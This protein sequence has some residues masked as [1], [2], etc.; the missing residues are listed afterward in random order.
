MLEK[1]TNKIV[2]DIYD[3]WKAEG[4]SQ[5][6]RTY[7]GGSQIGH[8]CERY[9]WYDFRHCTENVFSGRLYRLFQ[10]GHDEEHRF[11]KDLRDIGCEVWE[12]TEANEQFGVEACG[13]HFRGHLDGVARIPDYDK[14]H[15]LEFK[16]SNTKDF[17]KLEKED[18]QKES[19]EKQE[20]SSCGDN[21]DGEETKTEE[22]DETKAIDQMKKDSDDIKEE[23]Y[24]DF[25]N[26]ALGEQGQIHFE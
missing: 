16:T 19:E 6:R 25:D 24:T 12:E 3:K 18:E 20:S 10:R 4:D 26:G 11:V 8:H 22:S 14:P 23:T 7:L 5:T 1:F 17:K 13:G 9:L 15:L 2:E 21:G